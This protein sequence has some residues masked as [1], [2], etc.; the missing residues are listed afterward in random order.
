M[1]IHAT[2]REFLS[3]MTGVAL[4]L[5]CSGVH[6][7]TPRVDQGPGFDRVGKVVTGGMRGHQI[8]PA[9]RAQA[10][11]NPELARDTDQ[12]EAN[13]NRRKV[14]LT[15]RMFWIMLSMR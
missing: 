1:R 9:P 6:A 15:K 7:G 12:A 13:L 11:R 5:V 14:E 2:H 8:D 4:F 3:I 10:S